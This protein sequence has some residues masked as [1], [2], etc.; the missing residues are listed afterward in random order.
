[1]SK[2]KIIIKENKTRMRLI[3]DTASDHYSRKPQQLLST[4]TCQLHMGNHF[5]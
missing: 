4:H 2:K 5:Y 3:N 1:M